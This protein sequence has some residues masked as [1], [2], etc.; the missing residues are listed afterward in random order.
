MKKREIEQKLK[1]TKILN[2]NKKILQKQIS[3]NLKK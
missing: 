2:E 1:K 3:E